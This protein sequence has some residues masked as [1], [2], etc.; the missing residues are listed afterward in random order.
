M[1]IIIILFII[2]SKYFPHACDKKIKK[3]CSTACIC[4][5][6]WVIPNDVLGNFL[7]SAI[8]IGGHTETEREEKEKKLQ[9]S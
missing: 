6:A 7:T 2:F 1:F 4:F 8:Q 3:M 9:T 5:V